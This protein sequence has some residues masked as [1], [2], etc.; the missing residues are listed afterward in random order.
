MTVG[1]FTSYEWANPDPTSQRSIYASPLRSSNFNR[2]GNEIFIPSSLARDRQILIRG[3]TVRDSH[4]Y[5]K[6]RQTSFV[7]TDNFSNLGEIHKITMSLLPPL[8]LHL[9]SMI[10]QVTSEFKSLQPS[11]WFCP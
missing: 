8:K 11:V 4:I 1:E 6:S 9:T 7:L 5:D 10:L 2:E 3:L